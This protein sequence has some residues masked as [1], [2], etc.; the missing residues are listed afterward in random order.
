MLK[1]YW[2]KIEDLWYDYIPDW[3]DYVIKTSLICLFW[4]ILVG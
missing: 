2:K 4:I 1:E 3:A